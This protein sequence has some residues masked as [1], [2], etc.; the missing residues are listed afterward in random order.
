[1]KAFVINAPGETG[2]QEI[3]K[4]SPKAGE[5]LLRVRKVGFCG[6]DLAAFRGT[7]PNV[8]YP[9][10]PGHEIAATIEAAGPGVPDK[11]VAGTAVTV[12]PYTACGNCAA[13]RRGRPNACQFNQTF[14]V[15]RDGAMTEYIVAP[16]QKIHFADGLS[17]RDLCLVEPLSVGF[18]TTTRGRVTETDTVAV[19]GCGGVGLGAV[20]AAAFRGATTIAIDIDDAK[21]ALA[22]KAGARH[23]INS[24]GGHLHEALQEIT[25]GFGPD[26][27]IEAIGLPATYR[28]AIEEAAFTGR[29]VY[30]GY[31]K[32]PVAYETRLFV[33]KELDILG[34][35]NAGPED[36]EGVMTMLREGKFPVDDAITATV[37]LAQ[38]GEA[39]EQWDRDPAAVSKILVDIGGW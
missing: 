1:M 25:G 35:R 23:L 4:P 37:P 12:M 27:V 31:A 21:L 34:S 33:L 30:V 19:L 32:E 7:A 29:V 13:C 15:Q 18:H 38:A 24:A 9:R 16:W 6:T 20:A 10:I 14:G 22:R 3:S 11:F 36:F 2:F 5:V 39:L 17:W 8:T 28:A 26:V